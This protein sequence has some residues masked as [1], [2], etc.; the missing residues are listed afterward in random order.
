MEFKERVVKPGDSAEMYCSDKRRKMRCAYG[1]RNSFI[2]TLN[3]KLKILSY[4]LWLLIA[5]KK[6]IL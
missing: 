5:S 2:C 1:C 4:Q 6:Q 3:E